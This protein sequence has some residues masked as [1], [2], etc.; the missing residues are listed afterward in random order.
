LE[1]FSS[2]KLL[3][4]CKLVSPNVFSPFNFTLHFC[5]GKLGAKPDVLTWHRDVYPKEG[6]SGYANANPHNYKSI[7]TL[8]QLS[9]SLRA[10]Y[11]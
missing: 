2:T 11:L 4:R 1:Y 9:A 3:T 10:T 7:F 5:P 8:E 6:D